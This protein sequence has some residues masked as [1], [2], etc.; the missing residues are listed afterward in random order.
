MYA[1]ISY[2]D[3]IFSTGGAGNTIFYVDHVDIKGKR[4]MREI[5]DTL[6][7]TVTNLGSAGGDYALWARV[8]LALP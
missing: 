5:G 7:F 3:H 6:I 4:I 1:K 8:L 2:P